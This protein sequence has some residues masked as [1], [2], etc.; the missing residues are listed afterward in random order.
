MFEIFLVVP[1]EVPRPTWGKPEGDNSP[2][3][4]LWEATVDHC[5]GLSEPSTECIRFDPGA[6][7]TPFATPNFRFQ[8]QR[9]HK[10]NNRESAGKQW[11][12]AGSLAAIFRRP[13]QISA[14]GTDLCRRSRN[15][16]SKSQ[17]IIDTPDSRMLL[18]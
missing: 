15:S 13:L 10:L 1:S 18:D 5:G 4:R 9:S 2:E 3:A 8:L 14:D 11:Q 16:P 6:R 7:L 12:F 17:R